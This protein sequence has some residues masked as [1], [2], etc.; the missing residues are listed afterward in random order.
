MSIQITGLQVRLS[1]LTLLLQRT[2]LYPLYCRVLKTLDKA[3]QE[4]IKQHA[5]KVVRLFAI[6]VKLKVSSLHYCKDRQWLVLLPEVCTNPRVA[7]MIKDFE[8]S[9][10]PKQAQ[11]R[12]Y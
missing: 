1:C 12:I 11:N 10:R 9:S 2:L 8:A 5:Q 7:V 4:K 3:L 6:F